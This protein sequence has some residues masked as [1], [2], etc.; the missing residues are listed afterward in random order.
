MTRLEESLVF[1]R[2]ALSRNQA[3]FQRSLLAPTTVVSSR[4][5]SSTTK[6]PTLESAPYLIRRKL[7]SSGSGCFFL[8][9]GEGWAGRL[10][11][12]PKQGRQWTGR[13]TE[14][15]R[16][17]SCSLLS[18]WVEGFLWLLLTIS[19]AVRGMMGQSTGNQRRR[20]EEECAR[21]YIFTFYN[22]FVGNHERLTRPM[23]GA[24]ASSRELPRHHA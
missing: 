24:E 13:C 21:T 14:A 6:R 1:C 12:L 19:V 3:T 20:T 4:Q 18:E 9:L 10:I 15:L 16:V 11:M 2:V 17:R 7:A 22:E 8:S 23:D 5:P